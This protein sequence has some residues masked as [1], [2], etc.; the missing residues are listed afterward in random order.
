[1]VLICM[2]KNTRNLKLKLISSLFISG[3]SIT[4]AQAAPFDICPLSQSFLQPS[5]FSFSATKMTESIEFE[6][7]ILS[8]RGHY[9]TCPLTC[10]RYGTWIQGFSGSLRQSYD[11]CRYIPAYNA[12]GQGLIIGVD[13]RWNSN[14]KGGF[15]YAFSKENAY[16]DT[17]FDNQ[18]QINSQ[19]GFI[20]GRYRICDIYY[21]GVASFA[22]NT[23]KQNPDFSFDEI[24]Y[25][26]GWQ[27]N[28]R[29]EAG[30]DFHRACGSFIYHATPYGFFNYGHLSTDAYEKNNG[31][32]V[33]NEPVDMAQLGVGL[34]LS[35]DARNVLISPYDCFKSF[36]NPC[37]D[38]CF[39]DADRRLYNKVRKL[40]FQSTPYLRL[41]LTKDLFE[42]DQ[43]T[44]V[45]LQGSD[46]DGCVFRNGISFD[47]GYIVGAGIAL[48]FKNNNFLTFEYDYEGKSG[49]N[50]HAAYLKYRLEWC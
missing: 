2:I 31:L 21:S 3:V 15:A 8:R 39:K 10:E 35:Y 33:Q 45:H 44:N 16:V 4:G 36:L 7:D 29:L 13:R 23:Y 1:M 40:R 9:I 50:L 28:G 30:Y 26:T 38:K 5:L 37:I 34:L 42:A 18:L 11:E 12:K 19:Q 17:G 49:Y 32:S 46:E 25:F 27:F 43:L 22:L 14:F 6:A 41:A 48:D 47:H 24:D 20:F